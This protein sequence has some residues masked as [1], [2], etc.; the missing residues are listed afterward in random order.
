MS[1]CT[2][3]SMYVCVYVGKYVDIYFKLVTRK[4]AILI[5]KLTRVLLSSAIEISK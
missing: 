3:V 4:L 5:R 1:V 2:Y